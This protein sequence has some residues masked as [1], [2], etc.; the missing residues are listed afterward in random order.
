[1]LG[2]MSDDIAL[3]LARLQRQ[4][5]ERCRQRNASLQLGEAWKGLAGEAGFEPTISVLETE[6][7]GRAKLLAQSV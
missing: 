7:L 2:T 5:F 4:A 6:A 3:E 1:M